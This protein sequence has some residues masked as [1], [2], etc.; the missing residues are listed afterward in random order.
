MSE[1]VVSEQRNRKLRPSYVEVAMIVLIV[2]SGAMYVYDSYFAQKI[3]VVDI[4]GYLRQQK[5]LIVSGEI[6]AGELE[7]RL[8]K[9]DRVITQESQRHSN[10][11][12]I[13]KEVVL[14]NGNEFKLQ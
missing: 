13:L 12:Y 6:N 3:K 4:S 8:D 11:I 7:A 14:K 5:A 10:Q 2:V 9:I 1:S